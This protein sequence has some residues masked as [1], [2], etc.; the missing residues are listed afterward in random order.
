[1]TALSPINL[2]M[3]YADDTNLLIS[4]N[5][6]VQIVAKFDDIQTWAVENKRTINLA[7]TKEIVKGYQAHAAPL[8]VLPSNANMCEIS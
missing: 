6:D 2:L 8:T 3:K 5:T 1:M 4:C 7:K